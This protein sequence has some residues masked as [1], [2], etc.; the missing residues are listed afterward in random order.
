MMKQ[1]SP[2]TPRKQQ[3]LIA[4]FT[5]GN[6]KQN[7]LATPSRNT[8]M[9]EKQKFKHQ[10]EDE[11]DNDDDSMNSQHSQNMEKIANANQEISLS[12]ENT[13]PK[14]TFDTESL[15]EFP[16]LPTSPTKSKVTVNTAPTTQIPPES[17]VQQTPKAKGASPAIATTVNPASTME[18]G[19]REKSSTQGSFPPSFQAQGNENMFCSPSKPVKI[20][21][22][23]KPGQS[24]MNGRSMALDKSIR[25]KKR[26]SRGHVHCYDLRIKVKATKSDDEEFEVIQQSLQKF[27]DIAIQADSSSTIPP[28]FELDRQDR[29]ILELTASF[30]ISSLDSLESLKR[31]FSR[32][33]QRK[34][35]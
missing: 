16:P 19:T 25:L 5:K 32:L 22:V 23:S 35:K 33:S 34:D 2:G 12:E 3:I 29:T 11:A 18:K 17:E 14:E 27:F 8:S 30:P 9:S 26:V 4:S 21:E 20:P 24:N 13:L 15:D 6:K 10:M 28:Y 1:T 7:R 31:Y